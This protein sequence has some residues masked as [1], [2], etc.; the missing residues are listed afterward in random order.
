[1]PTYLDFTVSLQD[2]LPRPWR[3]FLLPERSTFGTLHSAIQDACGWGSSHLYDFRAAGSAGRGVIAGM[4]L[5]NYGGDV[6]Q[7]VPDAETARLASYFGPDKFTTCLY[8]Y[9]FGDSW[10]HD[11]QLN[12]VVKLPDKFTRRLLGGEHAFPPDDCGGSPGYAE[13][14]RVLSTGKDP[15]GLL[16]WA[17]DTWEWTGAFDLE[18][19]RTRFNKPRR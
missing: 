2:V 15:E 5:E 7:S 8:V 13:I 9:D 6:A 17:R 18:A 11:V 19:V 10:H 1:M 4:S 14:Q 12:D 3:R 16:D